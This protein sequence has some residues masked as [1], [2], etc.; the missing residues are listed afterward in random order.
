MDWETG[1]ISIRRNLV[2]VARGVPT[3][4]EPKTD[5]GRRRLGLD[6]EAMAAIRGHRAR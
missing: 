3:L 2:Q 6:D 4:A 5:R 1:R